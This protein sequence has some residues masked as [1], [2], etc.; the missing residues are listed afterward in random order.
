[1]K[2]K[3]NLLIRIITLIIILGLSLTIYLNG[4][5]LDCNKCELTLTSSRRGRD[6][7]SYNVTT[8]INIKATEMFETI[9]DGECRVSW[10]KI[11][12]FIRD[13]NITI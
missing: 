13:K 5:N 3:T 1:M 6:T 2:L 9:Q 12:G 4:K 10:D 7:A 8:K 11:Y